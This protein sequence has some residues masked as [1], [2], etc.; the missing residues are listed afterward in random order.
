MSVLLFLVV[1]LI[2][3]LVH[4]FGHFIVAKKSGIQVDE[5]GI[6]FPPKLFGI[7]IGETE[8][9]LNLLPIGGFV[10]IFGEN[11]DEESMKS[12]RSMVNKSKLV[13]SAVLVAGVAFNV[14]FAWIVFFAVFM[15][16]MPTAVTPDTVDKVS[17]VKL[18]ITGVIANSPAEAA[19]IKVGDS[20]SSLSYLR[21]VVNE[22]TGE[23]APN[24]IKSHD[25]QEININF[26]RDGEVMI[27]N[28]TPQDGI[29]GVQLREVG[30]VQYGFFESIYKSALF[31]V[32]M[33]GVITVGLVTF[34]FNA[35]TLQADF[36]QIA[37]PVGIV[38]LVGD[39]SSLGIIALLSFMAIIS[40]NL[41]VIN[42]L[43][44]PA[45]DG[46]R[47]LFVAIE[48]LKGSPIKPSIAN[49]LNTIGFALL[50]LLMIVVTYSDVVK[51]FN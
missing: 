10:R 2:L 15:I 29:I 46:G 11:P 32:K 19:E 13:Q 42:M 40:L 23:S 45:L 5:F 39:A 24:F 44:F 3:V 37:G 35:I 12:D 18:M 14:L 48:A 43:P 50:I 38:S 8:Y 30:T 4:E 34:L 28:I 27:T 16:G 25:G 33:L 51:I 22:P 7:K 6:G 47:L 49:G 31:T 17:D 20:I 1:L 36:S 26:I 9:T 41:A 21:E